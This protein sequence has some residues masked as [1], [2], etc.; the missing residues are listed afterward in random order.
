MTLKQCCKSSESVTTPEAA[1]NNCKDSCK[2]SSKRCDNCKCDANCGGGGG[3]D[4]TT[5]T[6]GNKCKCKSAGCC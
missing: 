2:V 3:D 4:N 1:G 6:D 5:K